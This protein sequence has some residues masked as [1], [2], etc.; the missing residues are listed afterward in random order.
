MVTVSPNKGSVKGGNVIR[1]RGHHLRDQREG[2]PVIKIGD[3]ALTNLRSLDESDSWDPNSIEVYEGTVPSALQAGTYP[4]TINNHWGATTIA[5]KYTY[6]AKPEITSISPASAANSGGS[7]VTLTGKNFGTIGT[8]SVTI[9]G[10]KSP[11][12][13]RI[14]D[15]KVVAMVPQT[16]TTGSVDVNIIAGT[17]GGSPDLPS[18]MA[19]VA[20]GTA[21]TISKVAPATVAIGGG[22]EV[23]LTGTG[24]GVAGTVGVRVGENC[25]K[26][27][28]STATSITFEAPSGDAAGAT[29]IIV[30]ATA[31]T[32]TKVGAL[33]Y[34]AT[35]GVT[36]VVPSSIASS[37][38]WRCSQGSHQR[39]WLRFGRKDQGRFCCGSQ[40]LGNRK[41]HQDYWHSH[42][43]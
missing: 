38:V 34:A 32:L 14:S 28:S 19:L 26:V 18:T 8:P 35:P 13:T 20:A 12:V 22:D 1:V 15:T 42:S 30:G 6:G 17:G 24:F 3:Q 31:A 11:C 39:C 25:A 16:A 40:L 23:V 29:D 4:I 37:A 33:T 21:P 27:I 5:T 43:D 9:D 41:W 2:N 7:L 10:I 36:S